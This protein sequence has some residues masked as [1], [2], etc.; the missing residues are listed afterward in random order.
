MEAPDDPQSCAL[1]RLSQATG[2]LCQLRPKAGRSSLISEGQAGNSRIHEN[3][4]KKGKLGNGL[5]WE[6]S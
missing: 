6:N 5:G 1:D 2:C 4:G 3:N